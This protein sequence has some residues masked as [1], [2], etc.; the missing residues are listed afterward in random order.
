MTISERPLA[1]HVVQRMAPGGIETLVLDLVRNGFGADLIFSLDGRADQLI[2]L[3]PALNADCC[4]LLAFDRKP[5]I[6][7]RLIAQ[8]AAQF[9]QFKPQ[10]VIVHH[11]GPLIYAGLAARLAGVR[12][13]VHVEHD[14]WQY[15]SRRRRVLMAAFARLLRPYHVAVSQQAASALREIFP[16]ARVSVIPPGID[17]ERFKPRDRAAARSRLGLDPGWLVVGTA[18][19][20]VPVKGHETLIDAMREMTEPIHI[21]I[22]GEGPEKERLKATAR[23]HG[24]E[25]R[26]HFL[27]HRDDLEQVLPAFDVFCLP[28]LAEGLPRGVLEAQ[29]CDLPV[30]ASNVGALKEAICPYTGSLVPPANPAAL[31]HALRQRLAQPAPRAA[32]RSFIEDQFSWTRT[33]ESYH[34]VMRAL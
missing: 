33:L 2:K 21:V 31:A 8:I 1:I 6:H 24:V 12:Q 15:Q 25:E 7:P 9:R 29:A 19:R 20:L 16:G 22:A 3:W 14:I 30:V 11:I 28:S 18:G 26:L 27:G 10:T 23:E 13:L 34:S 32:S 5:G 17:T 4:R